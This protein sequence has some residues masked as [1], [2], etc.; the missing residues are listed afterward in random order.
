MT[1]LEL[2]QFQLFKKCLNPLPIIKVKSVSVSLCW[3]LA[4]LDLVCLD[5]VC[6]DSVN[7]DSVNGDLVS[8]DS[9]SWDAFS[10]H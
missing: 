2:T 10:W 8:W 1:E 4:S 3:D 5:L 6:L 7:R 9:I